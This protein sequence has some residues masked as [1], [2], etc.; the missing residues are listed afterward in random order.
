ME[1]PQLRD[2]HPALCGELAPLV[3]LGALAYLASIGDER[4][5]DDDGEALMAMVPRH[6]AEVIVD[7]WENAPPRPLPTNEAGET[8]GEAQA[9]AE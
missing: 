4:V 7:R 1:R 8:P 2:L 5:S 9:L 6:L 3:L